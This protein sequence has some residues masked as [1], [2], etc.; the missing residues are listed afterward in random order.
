VRVR[1]AANLAV[2]RKAIADV[3]LAGKGA[4]AGQGGTP[5]SFGYDPDLPPY[6]TDPEKAKMLL[7]DAGFP[8]GFKASADVVVGSFP[9]DSEIY[10]QTA[11]DLKAVGIELELR[12]VTFPEWLQYFLKGTW[13]G[14]MFGSSWNTSP[15]MDSIRPYTYM[16]CMKK[17]ASFCDESMTPFVEAT[18]KEFDPTRRAELLHQL[19]AKTSEVL[20][21]IFLV[22][23]IDLS[24]WSSK[25]SGL[26]YANR[27][28]YYENVTVAK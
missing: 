13:P 6:P 23:Q 16:T 24:A 4:P 28:V 17:P 15:Y 21:A 10:Q 7:A 22:E 19:H 18:F 12:Q 3:L 5:A 11:Q 8:N 27:V 20:P 2:N 14:E 1:Q 9:A 26:E 25:V